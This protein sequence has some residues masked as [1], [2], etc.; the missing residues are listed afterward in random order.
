M[1]FSAGDLSETAAAANI[2]ACPLWK[3]MHLQ[4]IHK[5]CQAFS[6]EESGRLFGTGISLQN[7]SGIP[8]AQKELI[9]RVILPH[10]R[11]KVGSK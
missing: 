1:V 11:T 7:R 3:E 9:A 10:P 4:P 2:D 5:N 8:G 6:D